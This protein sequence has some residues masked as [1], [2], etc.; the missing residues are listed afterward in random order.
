MASVKESIDCLDVD[1]C[2]VAAQKAPSHSVT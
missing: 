1:I 2:V